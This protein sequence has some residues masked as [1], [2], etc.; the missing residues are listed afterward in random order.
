MPYIKPTIHSSHWP[1]TCQCVHLPNTIHLLYQTRLSAGH[2][3]DFEVL[4]TEFHSKFTQILPNHCLFVVIFL[5]TLGRILF[6]DQIGWRHEVCNSRDR[7]IWQPFP[8]SVHCYVTERRFL[9]AR[10]IVKGIKR[11]RI[12]LLNTKR[13]LLY[14]R[15][16]PIPRCKHFPLRL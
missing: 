2:Q 12:I 4:K 11:R 14:I 16:Q 15:N 7:T 3:M 9:Q 10:A 6:A 13:N 5:R 8:V 1:A